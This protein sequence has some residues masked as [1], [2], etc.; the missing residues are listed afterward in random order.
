MV[1][2]TCF[3]V[4]HPFKHLP[5]S[6]WAVGL[7]AVWSERFS[8][9]PAFPCAWQCRSETARFNFGEAQF[10]KFFLYDSHILPRKP[11]RLQ[12]W[13]KFPPCVSDPFQNQ[14]S[15]EVRDPCESP[16]WVV[17]SCRV[18]RGQGSFLFLQ[19]DIQLLW[20][21]LLE[22]NYSFP[23]IYFGTFVENQWAG[24]WVDS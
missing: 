13:G 16:L 9:S 8:L 19:R 21:Q 23:L 12:S 2:S 3:P 10:I 15:E 14:L 17:G 22:K 1:L 4:E 7:S 24:E 18:Q 6:C 5:V 11:R 20:H